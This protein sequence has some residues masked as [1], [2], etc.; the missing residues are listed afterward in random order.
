MFTDELCGVSLISVGSLSL[1]GSFSL[2]HVIILRVLRS[3]SSSLLLLSQLH[4]LFLSNSVSPL[5]FSKLGVVHLVAL[6]KQVLVNFLWRV[7]H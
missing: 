2:E 7:N 5:E 1:R 3:F 4:N 6:D